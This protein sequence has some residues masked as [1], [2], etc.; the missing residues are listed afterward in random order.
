MPELRRLPFLAQ[1]GRGYRR[2]SNGLYINQGSQWRDPLVTFMEAEES[3]EVTD[4][5]NTG[6]P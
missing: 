4:E 3:A 2:R 1:E 6:M 5:N